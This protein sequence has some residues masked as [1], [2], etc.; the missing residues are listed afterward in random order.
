M[1]LQVLRD[2]LAGLS[3]PAGCTLHEHAIFIARADR[4][5]VELGFRRIADRAFTAK[6]F[7]DAAVEVAHIVVAEC[8]VQRQ[9]GETVLHGAEGRDR[10]GSH[11]LGG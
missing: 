3:V 8:V 9:H 5:S 11:S 4:Q 10:G 1:V 7:T 2:V 6:P